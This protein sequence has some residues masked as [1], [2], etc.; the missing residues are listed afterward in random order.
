MVPPD[1]TCTEAAEASIV[2]DATTCLAV[3]SAGSQQ[4]YMQRCNA[5]LTKA[6][7]D[8]QDDVNTT[9][10]DLQACTFTGTG[11]CC[12]ENVCLFETWG[13]T[14]TKCADGMGSCTDPVDATTKSS[15]TGTF[16]STAEWK[17]T[18]IGS[19][20]T[21]GLLTMESCTEH[22]D[23]GASITMPLHLHAPVTAGTCEFER[24]SIHRGLRVAAVSR[25][26]MICGG[27][28]MRSPGICSHAD[29]V[30]SVHCS[31]ITSLTVYYGIVK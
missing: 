18:S 5:V 21:S 13:T 12:R 24:M 29:Q 20:D 25:G 30:S 9:V 17:L 31:D 2:E 3:D 22:I 11:V 26:L 1:S 28:Q 10:T 16:T 7:D 23:Q 4:E 19:A 27:S 8:N 15:C 14:E 6:S